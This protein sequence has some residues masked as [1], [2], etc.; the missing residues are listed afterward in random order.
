MGDGCFY[1]L[2]FLK[3]FLV[4]NKVDIFCFLFSFYFKIKNKIFLIKQ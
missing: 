2:C 3:L 1:V 4:K